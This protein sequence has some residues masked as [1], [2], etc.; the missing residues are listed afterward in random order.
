MENLNTSEVESMEYMFRRCPLTSLDLSHFNTANLS[1]TQNMFYNCSKLKTIYVSND[2]T[3]E[4]VPYDE[5]MF[6]GCT[7]LVGGQGTT[8]NYSE[9]GKKYA[10]TSMAA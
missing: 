5:Y 8:F 3:V 1:F 4:N 10:H 9:T 2:W 6:Y 7:N